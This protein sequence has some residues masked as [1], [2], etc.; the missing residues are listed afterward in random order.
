MRL[1]EKFEINHSQEP[2]HGQH[3]PSHP[4]TYLLYI[5][6]F[7]YQYYLQLKAYVLE[8]RLSSDEETAVLLA[9]YSTQG[10]IN[11]TFPGP[12]GRGEV[13][14]GRGGGSQGVGRG[15]YSINEILFINYNSII[16]CNILNHLLFDFIFLC[17]N[18]MRK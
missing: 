11:S 2:F 1:Q 12:Y 10:I 6:A 7:R 18:F 9:S 14:V 4:L 17:V 8:R 16:L 13:G 3:H 5:F 15:V